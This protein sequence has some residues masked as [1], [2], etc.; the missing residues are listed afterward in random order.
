[1][2]RKPIDYMGKKI[3]S[4]K[5]AKATTKKKAKRNPIST[6][7]DHGDVQAILKQHDDD[8]IR[9]MV[10]EPNWRQTALANRE[11]GIQLVRNAQRRTLNK[12]KRMH[13]R[14]NQKMAHDEQIVSSIRS[15][16]HPFRLHE[17]AFRNSLAVYVTTAKYTPTNEDFEMF[18]NRMRG[19][20]KVLIKKK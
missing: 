1:M 8:I 17:S 2:T 3:A 11:K 9:S 18:L 7:E 16:Q 12:L 10:E 13:N 19:D 15:A 14:S 4:M 20:L 6:V 5:R